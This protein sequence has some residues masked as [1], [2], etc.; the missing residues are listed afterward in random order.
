MKLRRV[1][2]RWAAAALIIDILMATKPPWIEAHKIEVAPEQLFVSLLFSASLQ[3]PLLWWVNFMEAKRRGL[4]LVLGMAMLFH[5]S[6]LA[7]V[8]FR[9]RYVARAHAVL[10]MLYVWCA[11]SLRT[12]AKK[13][14]VAT[15]V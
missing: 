2:P 11:L 7:L 3:W 15:I 14:A 5:R 8:L 4:S 12:S 13:P 10:A 1:F 9:S 6:T